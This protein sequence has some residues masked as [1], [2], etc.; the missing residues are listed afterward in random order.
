MITLLI[1]LRLLHIIGGVV[2]A[3]A[4]LMLTFIVE[5]A[6]IASGED[7]TRFMQQLT[8]QG[9]FANYMLVSAVMT[10]AAGASLLWIVSAGFSKA[11]VSSGPG[12]GFTLGGVAA[13]VAFFI[14]Y[15]VQNRTTEHMVHLGRTITTGGNP[16]NQDQLAMLQAYRTRISLGGR[17]TTGFLILAVLLMAVSR[18]LVF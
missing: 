18:Y 5:P 8:T 9:R 17:W 4:S 10:V 16:P 12:L 14:G 13:L 1:I 15:L 3:G 7:G 6:V 11:W 2:W